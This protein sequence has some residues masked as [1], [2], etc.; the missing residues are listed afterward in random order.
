MRLRDWQKSGV[1]TALSFAVAFGLSEVLLRLFW[2]PGS[3]QPVIRA[4]PIYGWTLAPSTHLHSVDTDRHLRYDIQVNSLGMRDP[5]RS[6]AKPA[7]M[8]RVL[9]L[10]DS[11]V[12]GTGVEVGHR[13]G[14]LLAGRLGPRVEVLHAACG[15]WGT[16]QEFLYLCREGFAFQPDVV[17]LALCLSNDVANNLLAHELYG[18]AAKPRFT[19]QGSALGSAL[20]YEPPAFRSA[21]P[22][23]S[24]HLHFLK[25]SRLLHFV[26]RHVRF[27]HWRQ[28]AAPKVEAPYYDEDLESGESHWAVFE[29]EYP[30]AFAAAFA[31]TEALIAA[32]QDSCATHGVPLLLFAFPQKFEVDAEARAA[33]LAHYGYEA[34]WFD[35]EAPYLRLRQLAQRLEIPYVHPHDEFVAASAHGPLFFARD[36]HP[37]AAGHALAAQT[38]EEPVRR[39]LEAAASHTALR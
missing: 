37:D 28:H 20:V 34:A 23:G 26:G 38:L 32:I 6:R 39:A 4:D 8:R 7:G 29:K 12:F 19:L 30:P 22:S 11:M 14:D 24:K 2:G 10:G 3:Y 31:V 35:L 16:D 25:R 21:A 33:E 5:E 13:C 27:L 1:L 17:I 15:G 18:T 9:L 36:G